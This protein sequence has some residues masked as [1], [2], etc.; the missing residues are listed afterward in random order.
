[1]GLSKV[2]PETD[3]SKAEHSNT[4]QGLLG[5]GY[6]LARNET[7]ESIVMVLGLFSTK[8]NKEYDLIFKF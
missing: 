6:T 2:V 4:Q 1:V 7:H 8:S 5:F 3:T